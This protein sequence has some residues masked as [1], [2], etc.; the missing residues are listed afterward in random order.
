[1]FTNVIIVI[2]VAVLAFGKAFSP[3]PKFMRKV[4]VLFLLFSTAKNVYLF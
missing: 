4:L 3:V 1:M 2:V